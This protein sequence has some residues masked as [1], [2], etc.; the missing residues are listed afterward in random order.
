MTTFTEQTV[1]TDI[2]YKPE[3]NTFEV[4]K[5]DRVYK[6]GVLF[7][8]GLPNRKAYGQPQ[9]DEFIAEVENGL[10]HASAV[11]W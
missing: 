6:D 4:K 9:K 11:G 10:E 7:S 8:I 2:N 1:F 5:E 3:S